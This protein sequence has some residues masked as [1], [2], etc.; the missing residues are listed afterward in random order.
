MS[1]EERKAKQIAGMKAS[2]KYQA[3]KGRRPAHFC[4][5][6]AVA[7]V[8][9][10]SKTPEAKAKWRATIAKNHAAWKARALMVFQNPES[11]RKAKESRAS[12][13]RYQ[14]AQKR[15]SFA[16]RRAEI[17]EISSKH[18]L[19]KSDRNVF[20]EF[21]NLSQWVRDNSELFDPEDVQWKPSENS[22]KATRGLSSLRPTRKK[23]EAT[24]KGWTWVS[25][26]E[27]LNGCVSADVDVEEKI[28]DSLPVEA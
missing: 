24:W 28:C 2:P 26:T 12:S 21:D 6:E 23:P 1:P 5:Q 10:A 18:W 11:Q 13:P 25:I 19:L 16:F 9:A 27:R 8:V 20:Y 4:T 3:R 22:C 14:E 17:I 7:K 15:T